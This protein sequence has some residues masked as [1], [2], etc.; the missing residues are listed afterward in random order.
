MIHISTDYVFDGTKGA[1][2]TEFDKPNPIDVYGMSKLAGEEFVQTILNDFLIIRTA[3]MFGE[4]RAHFVDYVVN[5]ILKNDEIVAVKDMVSS[6]TYSFDMANGIKKLM[7]LNQ[8]GIFHM[9]NKGYAS[10]VEMIEE[11]F[12]IMKK[13]TTVKVMN[14]SQW[15]R[16]AKRPVF[17]AL[18][19]YHLHLMDCDEMPGWRD[20][21][22][23]YIKYK[24]KRS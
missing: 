22:R 23:R 7:T 5:G 4:K 8:T 3:W 11:I 16:P 24:F 12:K 15:K 19:N 6:P 21:I 14:Q 17:S 20:A 1:P 18:L 13:Q 2:Y 9:V 10:R